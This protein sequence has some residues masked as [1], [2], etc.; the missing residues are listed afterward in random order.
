MGTDMQQT[1]HP[2][3]ER[4][5][6]LYFSPTGTTRQVV[7]AVAQSLAQSLGRPV[8]EMSW[9]LP[10]E[11][12]PLSRMGPQDLLVIGF[13]VYAGRIPALLDP[14]WSTLQGNGALA[15]PV[16][17]YGNRDYDDALLEAGDRL[18]EAGFAL[19]GAAAFIGEHSLTSLAG[20]GRPNGADLDLAR[21]FGQKLAQKLQQGEAL[22]ALH[23][24]GNRPYKERKPQEQ[25]RPITTEACVGCGICADHC[26]TGAIRHEA[27]QAT[28]GG[29]I[30]CC[31]CVKGCPMGARFFDD[32]GYYRI[33]AMLEENC[34][35][36]KEP[37]L[38]GV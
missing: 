2:R 13:P 7:L 6:A 38:F 17:V 21:G 30:R 12:I 5:T 37:E 22:P 35:T 36:P 33:K 24:K 9:T 32:E 16:A 10:Q 29:C 27:P 34:R 18:Q 15:V 1:T 31:A 20:T 3:V 11:R 8:E 14:V 23:L 4:V 28:D 26:P 19:L 25:V